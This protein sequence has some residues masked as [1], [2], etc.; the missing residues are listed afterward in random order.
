[1]QAVPSLVD[2]RREDLVYAVEVAAE[3]AHLFGGGYPRRRDTEVQAGVPV[4]AKEQVL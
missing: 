4:D 3:R 2:Y 1:M